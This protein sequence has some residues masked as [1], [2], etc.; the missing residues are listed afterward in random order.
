MHYEYSWLYLLSEAVAYGMG[1]GAAYLAWRLVRAYERR[2]A[3]LGHVDRLTAR[4]DLLEDAAAEVAGR[5]D[6]VAEAQRFTT[7]VLAGRAAER[8]S[9][10]CLHQQ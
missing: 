5:V 3:A 9:G 2:V 6:Q 1:G 8:G 10:T 4:V 7:R